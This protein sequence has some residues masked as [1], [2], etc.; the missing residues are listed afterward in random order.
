MARRTHA[1]R[2]WVSLVMA[3]AAVTTLLSA[4]QA[5][6]PQGTRVA[7]VAIHDSR[8]L[9]LCPVIGRHVVNSNVASSAM[10]A[11]A[12]VAYPPDGSQSIGVRSGDSLVRV[13]LPM[14]GSVTSDTAPPTAAPAVR[15]LERLAR[16]PDV[17]ARAERQFRA[18]KKYTVVDSPAEADLVFLVESQYV[19]LA[20]SVTQLPPR[21]D[22]DRAQGGDT[23]NRASRIFADTESEW[24]RR[25]WLDRDDPTAPAGPGTA[26]PGPWPPRPDNPAARQGSFV[27]LGVRGG[28]R[29]ATWRES[30]VAIAVPA[31]AYR[32]HI[33]DGAALSAA[34]VW[35]GISG[36]H[37]V[38]RRWEDLSQAERDRLNYKNLTQEQ[39]DRGPGGGSVRAASPEALVD[40]FHGKGERMPADLPVCAATM[41]TVPAVGDPVATP[42]LIPSPAT[43]APLEPAPAAPAAVAPGDAARFRSNI[44]LV[45]VPI[46]VTDADGR[47]ITDLP[48]SAFHI[49]EDGIEQKVDRV[50][51]GT[52]PAHIAL[53]IDTSSGMRTVIEGIR[54]VARSLARALRPDDQA[55]VLSFDGRIQVRSEFTLDRAATERAI[56]QL[57]QRGQT[58]LYDAVT[59][60]VMDR[61][62][63]IDH[64]KAIVLVTDGVDTGSQLTDAAGALAA[65]DTSNVGVYV[66]RYDTSDA[67][68]PS[69]PTSVAGQPWR[70]AVEE[71]QTKADARGA[72]DR[73]LERL[74]AGSGGR[75]YM[76]RPTVDPRELVEQVSQDLSQQYVLYYYPSNAT[77]DGTY[78]EIRVT[79]DR[80]GVTV[81]ARTGYRAGALQA[82]P[83]PSPGRA[84]GAAH[85]R[86]SERQ[87]F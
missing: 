66:V 78:R 39:R 56:G 63:R 12:S 61:L 22:G 4:D 59:L 58:R 55:M 73:F 47:R 24:R 74:A 44:T 29:F 51:A 79:V 16:D 31:D 34:R 7:V 53:L 86:F 27:I 80:P 8:L 26:P 54:T 36:V 87:V 17:Q 3:A 48:L 82:D 9:T 50:E 19:P 14:P 5:K 72:G 20:T 2:A 10:K 18:L 76:A 41:G 70:L 65:V 38:R 45:T 30:S 71:T 42:A 15:D 1:S 64:R 81:R 13:S 68:G 6:L 69:L 21:Q 11:E 25:M 83:A 57:R 60:A 40:M 33:G 23:A 32:Q 43:T 46:T 28:D 77:L 52:E 67:P 62:N 49:V 85:S 35:Q 75:L 84:A 37:N